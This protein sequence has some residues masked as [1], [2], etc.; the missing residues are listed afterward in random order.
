M[1]CY[2]CGTWQSD[3]DRGPSPWQRGVV[4]EHL[5]LVCPACQRQAGW[6]DALTACG[7]CGSRH[8]IRRLDLVE[9]LDCRMTREA[10]PDTVLPAP[11]PLR[12]D[13]PAPQPLR[14]DLPAPQPLRAEL[15]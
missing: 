14:A 15:A 6:A 4:A 2:R 8:L 11:Q 5:V 3:P 12:A 1:P 9:C 10:A 7:R 13:L